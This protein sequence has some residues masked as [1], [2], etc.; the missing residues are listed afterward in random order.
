M[1]E[2]T[3]TDLEL[4][5]ALADDLPA[6]RLAS[7]TPA[8]RVRLDELR[9]EHAAFLAQIDVAAEVRAIGRR[10]EQLTPEA[11]RKKLAAWWRWAMTG[12]VLAAAAATLLL[13]LHRRDPGG[14][15]IDDDDLRTKGS[16]ITLVIHTPTRE[17]ATGDAVAPGEKIR[18]EIGAPARGYVAVFGVDGAGATTIYYPFGAT[19]PGLYDPAA[20]RLLPGAIEL[21]AIAGTERFYA[22]YA[23]Q[24]FAIDAV[25]HALV[26]KRSVAGVSSAE[27]V[28]KKRLEK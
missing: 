22:V 8:D 4:E 16:G 3:L 18:F 26:E 27:V 6:S 10:A 13:V 20:T 24:P 15:G 19:A 11:P 1:A 17:L 7:A 2:R 23:A 5:R 12:G 28:L 21:D 9:A 14:Q 25:A